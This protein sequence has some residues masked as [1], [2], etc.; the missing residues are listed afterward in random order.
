MAFA[1]VV[2][3]FL[4][5]LARDKLERGASLGT[6]EQLMGSHTLGSAFTI[7]FELRTLNLLGLLLLS[8]WLLSPLGG[9]ALIR[10]LHEG[11]QSSN[12]RALYFD[13]LRQRLSSQFFPNSSYYSLLFS[14]DSIKQGP[15]DL[16]GNVKIPL[17]SEDASD[18]WTE[19]KDTDDN[20][21]YSSLVGIPVITSQ[22]GNSTF[23]LE[24][25]HISLSCSPVTLSDRELEK[26]P[27]IGEISMAISSLEI[28]LEDISDASLMPN[29]SWYGVQHSYEGYGGDATEIWWT[30]GLDRFVDEVWDNEW[31]LSS[32]NP[33][34]LF[35]NETSVEA[36]PTH[37]I[38][39]A[40][41][42]ISSPSS[43]ESSTRWGIYDATCRVFQK[44]VE[45]RVYCTQT[46]GYPSRS[47][48]VLAQRAS[49]NPHPPEDISFL[50]FPGEFRVVSEYLP[51]A[52]TGGTWGL[53]DPTLYHLYD[54]SMNDYMESIYRVPSI[55]NLAELSSVDLGLR[56]GQAINTWYMLAQLSL[57]LNPEY[58]QAGIQSG[59]A[60]PYPSVG[61]ANI[62]PMVS[63]RNVTTQTAHA[64]YGI[65]WPWMA[66]CIVCCTGLAAAGILGVIFAHRGRGPELLGFTSAILRDSRYVDIDIPERG[67]GD[68]DGYDVS[69]LL[70][71]ERL[72][73]GHIRH[74][75]T[76]EMSV[77]IGL[78][79]DVA[80]LSK[81][82]IEK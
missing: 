41:S 31:F 12:T 24:S 60:E 77:G 8:G 76:G 67:L 64:A 62:Y 55:P 1:F 38:F 44:Y 73:Y 69:R 81:G 10:V 11:S 27:S 21:T 4:Y 7:H 63:P 61:K 52:F 48:R 28:E 25:S 2:S 26:D 68:V 58:W 65:S 37:L 43:N 66:A 34:R 51:L 15:E 5:H 33:V 78:E 74:G 16:W 47:C 19:L 29:G 22:D 75:D 45:S 39:Q 6:L 30:L 42:R 82:A 50:S 71:H 53:A 40:R 72:R 57:S 36:G 32:R 20:P 14:P 9:Q 49:Q 17:L 35:E 80:I 79:D 13:T 54:P 23:V 46:L 59:L 3:R 70:K 18:S 56:L